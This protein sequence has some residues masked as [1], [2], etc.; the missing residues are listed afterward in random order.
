MARD[1]AQQFTAA[2]WHVTEAKYGR[3]LHA[4]FSQPGGA[5][6][7][8]WI[9]AMPNEHYQSLF[10]LDPAGVR[11][12]FCDGAPGSASA[13]LGARDDRKTPLESWL[14]LLFGPGN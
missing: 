3:R 11:A 7:R 5:A 10:G 9:D 6:L 1:Q 8:D 4:V 12:R 2:G 14:S 13:R